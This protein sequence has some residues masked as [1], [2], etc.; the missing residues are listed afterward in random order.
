MLDESTPQSPQTEQ[1]EQR[2][3]S[4]RVT[5]DTDAK[6]DSA[7]FLQVRTIPEA[8]R[9]S[10]TDGI[11]EKTLFK[12]ARAIRAF[13]MTTDMRIKPSEV[14]NVFAEWWRTAQ[15]E[16]RLPADASFD[17]YALL[18]EDT[19]ARAKVPLGANALA[20]AS[21]RAETAPLPEAA[22][23]FTDPKIQK[24]VG[25]GFQLQMLA[26]SSPF[27]L[28]VRDCAKI[29]G[30][31]RLETASAILN[32]FVR[33]GVFQLHKKG[34]PGGKMASRFWYGDAKGAMPAAAASADDSKPAEATTPPARKREMWQLLLDEK[35][36]KTRLES[37][38]ESTKPDK[39]IMDSLRG[40]LKKVKAEIRSLK[41]AKPETPLAA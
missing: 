34:S 12:F 31:K 36:L 5:N 28:S 14:S 19:F 6:D 32:G 33:R 18:F 7:R 25:I 16:K 23:Q 27:F 8:V 15:A 35:A 20:T 22:K 9:L 3:G 30:T 2:D 40:E 13:E 4:A 1:R 41:P 37:E 24:L 10:L 38:R 17:E 29:Y 26:G 21:K 39:E 11:T